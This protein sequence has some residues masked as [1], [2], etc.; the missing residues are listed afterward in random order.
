MSVA[1]V[2]EITSSSKKSFQDAIE[3]GIARAAKTLKNLEGAWVQDQKIVIQDGKI[4]AY[5]V[6]M[7]V[8]FILTDG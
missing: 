2:T 1:R 5:R 8:T 6:N 7:K 4:A 3:K